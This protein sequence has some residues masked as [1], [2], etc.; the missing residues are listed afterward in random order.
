MR[1]ILYVSSTT[2][3][4]NEAELLSILDASRRNNSKVG[5][6]GVLMYIDGGFMQVLEG[7]HNAVEQTLAR[8][9]NDKRHWNATVLMDRTAPRCFGEWSMGFQRPLKAAADGIFTIT[10][11]AVEGRVVDGGAAEIM[12]LLETFYRVQY[13]LAL[14]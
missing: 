1:Q 2:R 9:R 8:I 12:R 3:D 10:R 13:G 14:T 5:V 11:D 7:E 4:V 6:S